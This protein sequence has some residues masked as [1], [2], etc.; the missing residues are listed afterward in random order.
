MKCAKLVRNQY[1]GNLIYRVSENTLM[2]ADAVI[3]HIKRNKSLYKRLVF[4]LAL[5]MFNGVVLNGTDFLV[6]FV[7]EL[8]YAYNFMSSSEMMIRVTTLA[9]V[10]LTSIMTGLIAISVFLDTV[11][12]QY[13]KTVQALKK[14]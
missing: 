10:C 1:C 9:S 14:H 11:K 4:I 3:K 7:E 12:V 8:S 5:A 2:K 6:W 13:R